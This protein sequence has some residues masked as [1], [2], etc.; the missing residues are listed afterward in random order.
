MNRVKSHSMRLDGTITY[1]NLLTAAGTIVAVA[2]SWGVMT[3]RQD[4]AE[5]SQAAQAQQFTQA[6]ARIDEA[7]KEQRTDQKDLARAVQTITTDTAL[8]RG[9]L[10]SSDSGSNRNVK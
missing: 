6:I 8:I 2:V 1:G 9:R 10:A 3:A 7:L 4:A 5:K